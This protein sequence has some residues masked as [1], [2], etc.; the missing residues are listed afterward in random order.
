MGA[1]LG[2]LLLTGALVQLKMF[3][4]TKVKSLGEVI[5]DP[6]TLGIGV[7]LPALIGAALTAK[8]GDQITGGI[9]GALAGAAM[10]ALAHM[11]AGVVYD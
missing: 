7:G 6:V 3:K 8:Q 5:K 2:A 10:V 11:A 9:I 1:G 4:Q